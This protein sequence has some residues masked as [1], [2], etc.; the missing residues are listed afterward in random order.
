MGCGGSKHIIS[1]LNINVHTIPAMSGEIGGEIK[2]DCDKN[3]IC[4]W[5]NNGNTALL[6]LSDDRKKASN[7]P[8]GEY[9]IIC[10]SQNETITTQVFVEQLKIP[11]VEEYVVEHAT[12]DNSRDGKIRVLIANIDMRNVQYL[13]TTG[14][15]TD[16]P[17]L[18]NVRPGMYAVTLVSDEQLPILFYHTIKPAVVEVK[19]NEY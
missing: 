12:A 13:W 18:Y 9:Q 4:E 8:P 16:E 10:T 14:I 11:R 2:I 19:K 3:I 6:E 5:R 15:V 1:N 7:V 17:I